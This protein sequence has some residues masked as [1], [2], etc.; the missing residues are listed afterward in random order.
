MT[1]RGRIKPRYAKMTA[2]RNMDFLNGCSN[3]CQC[4]P[5]P[6]ALENT[7]RPIGKGNTA[8]IIARLCRG[9]ERKGIDHTDTDGLMPQGACQAGAD[10]PATGNQHIVIMAFIHLCFFDLAVC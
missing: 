7:S 6:H 2:V 1:R 9:A 4:R 10:Q 8:I 3:G 5:Q